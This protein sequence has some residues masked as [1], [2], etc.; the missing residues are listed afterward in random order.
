[1]NKVVIYND[2]WCS[3]G[4]ESMIVSLLTHSDFSDINITILVGQKETNI[5]DS[6]LD[7]I[8]LKIVPILGKIHT[9]YLTEVVKL[10]N[11]KMNV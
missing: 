10:L 8:G 4:V 1:M 3:G 11:P 2:R 7:K 6:C 9:R 5:Y